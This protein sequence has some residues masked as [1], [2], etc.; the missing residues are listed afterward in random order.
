VARLEDSHAVV[1]AGTA[2]PPAP[3]LPKW[4]PGLACLIDDR[5]RMVVYSVDN[6]S[7]AE[8]AEV[9]PGMTVVSINGVPADSAIAQWTNLLKKYYG[10]SSERALRYDAVRDCVRQQKRGAL[11]SIAL[12]DVEGKRKTVEA[13]ALLSIRYLPRLPVPRRGIGDSAAL[14]WVMLENQIGYIYVRRVLQGLEA[15]LDRA[16]TDMPGMKGLIIDVR[17]NSGGGFETSTA[18][19]N[20]D[21]ASRSSADSK[22]PLYRGPIALLIDERTISAGEG[23]A[24][25]FIANKRARV[26][27]TTT[28]GASS[29]KETYTLSNGLYKV[30]VPVKA[31]TGFLDRPIERLGL[32]PD[33]EVRCSAKDLAEARDTVVETASKWLVNE[34]GK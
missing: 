10:Y 18:F 6:G 32:Q 2:Q 3:D 7:P 22:R 31:Y 21:L 12:D 5:G 14:S 26:F 25:W 1:Q 24:S 13:A 29:R 33:V 34:S 23:W 20:F 4:D 30:V 17:G 16:I 19:Q 15:G 9:K 28:A 27:G 11:V 8:K